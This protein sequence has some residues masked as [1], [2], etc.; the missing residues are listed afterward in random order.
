MFACQMY[1]VGYIIYAHTY[2]YVCTYMCVYTM[3]V[4]GTVNAVQP[5]QDLTQNFFTLGKTA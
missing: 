5:M 1:M 3:C 4:C 2:M